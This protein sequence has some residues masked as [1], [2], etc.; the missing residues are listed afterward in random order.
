MVT[1]LQYLPFL[2]VARLFRKMS[3]GVSAR[4][5]GSKRGTIDAPAWPELE[6]LEFGIVSE[7][8]GPFALFLICNPS[9]LCFNLELLRSPV[10]EFSLPSIL[11]NVVDLD[12]TEGGT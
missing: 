12:E 3:K 7:A 5:L 2:E 6:I 11:K 10:T 4:M 8:G 1:L 9:G